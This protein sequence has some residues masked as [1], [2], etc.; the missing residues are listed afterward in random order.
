MATPMHKKAETENILRNAWQPNNI[1]RNKRYEEIERGRK[2]TVG[3]NVT[4]NEDIC[5]HM[6]KVAGTYV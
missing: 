4:Q 5:I 6:E 1:Y 3:E 2:E